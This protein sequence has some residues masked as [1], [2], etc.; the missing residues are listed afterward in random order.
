M[1]RTCQWRVFEE[2]PGRGCAR[3]DYHVH[4]VACGKPAVAHITWPGGTTYWYCAVHYDK[5]LFFI[6]E[7]G[8]TDVLELSGVRL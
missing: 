1:R 4:E 8:R 3:E 6:R 2:C 5:R 7:C